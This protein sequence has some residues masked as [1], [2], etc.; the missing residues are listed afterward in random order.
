MRRR[1]GGAGGAGRARSH[2]EGQ[3]REGG[4]REGVEAEAGAASADVK[5]VAGLGN[6]GARVPRA[7]GTTS[8]SRSSICWPRRHR[9]WRSRLA[10]ADALRGAVAPARRRRAARQAA[11]VHEPERR[12][13]RRAERGTTRSTLPDVLIVCDDVNLPLGRLRARASGSE[14]GHNGLRS[15][16]A[17][18]RA[19][20]TTRGSGSAWA[21]AMCGA[22]W[23]TTCWPGSSPTNRPGWK[24]RLPGPPTP[25]RC[26]S[27][28]GLATYDEYVQPRGRQRI[29][30]APCRFQ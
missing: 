10:P 18:A 22:T 19:R 21:A 16:A 28:D 26:G 24:T 13:G 12:G 17:A 23:P 27:A 25:S 7:R 14:G 6:P 15:I 11:D 3:G 29:T 8:G 5:L 20:S 30:T 1:G 9:G 2:Q 4:R